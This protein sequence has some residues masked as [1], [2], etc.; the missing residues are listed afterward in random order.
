[1]PSSTSVGFSQ[2]PASDQRGGR[3]S[4]S[5]RTRQS[6]AEPFAQALAR[7]GLRAERRPHRR[8]RRSRSPRR[9]GPTWCCSTWRLPDSDGRDVCRALRRRSDVPIIM[10][11]ARGTMTDR[12]VGLE[13]GADDY[14]VKPFSVAEVIARI[15][16]VLRRAPAPTSADAELAM[17][18]ACAS[19][20]PARRV[21]LRRRG[22]RADPQGVRPARAPGARRRAGGHARGAD[23]GRLG[24]ELVR[25]DQDARR[26]HRV[27]A[28]QAR[29]R[30]GRA[31]RTS[32][33][34]AASASGSAGREEVTP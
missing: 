8:A 5:S 26:P 29:R 23:V 32:T 33:P 1:M 27:A 31:A 4:C 7:D 21:W 17:P 10:V 25:L 34:C 14:V 24:H 15:R 28:A 18:G 12:V 3:W 19:T 2:S 30:P 9:S 6:I 22:A 16:A 20:S 11:T 13:L